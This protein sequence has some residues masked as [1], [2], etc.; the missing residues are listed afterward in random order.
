MSEDKQLVDLVVVIGSSLQVQ[1]VSLVPF[2]I[3]ED[4]PQILINKEDLSSY[5]ADVKLI[6][7]CDSIII[8]LCMAI[9]GK[10]K[11]LMLNELKSRS[12]D[13]LTDL[14]PLLSSNPD[15]FL[16]TV[17]SADEIKNQIEE[18][19]KIDE[20]KE[21]LDEVPTKRIKLDSGDSASMELKEAENKVDELRQMYEAKY[22]PVASKLTG[23]VYAKF[24]P[25]LNIFKGADFFYNNDQK[26]FGPL[27]RRQQTNNDEDSEEDDDQNSESSS[28][29]DSS[30]HYCDS[31]P[32]FRRKPSQSEGC[33]KARNA[34]SCPPFDSDSSAPNSPSS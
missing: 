33:Q 18:E 3:E 1:P 19:T 25:N 23:H 30:N 21:E 34:E 31:A 11:E 7:D 22:I 16:P 5:N 8:S 4:V 6:G 20:P 15:K 28:S 9:G 29:D 17:I 10:F 26:T 32:E 24:P 2:N 12:H 27:P 13:I 14:E